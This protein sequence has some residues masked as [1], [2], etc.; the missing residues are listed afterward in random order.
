MLPP[1]VI[2]L[3]LHGYRSFNP[4]THLST[5][6]YSSALKHYL[7]ISE[8]HKVGDSLNLEPASQIGVAIG[9]YFQDNRLPCQIVG[10]AFH[11]GRRHPPGAAP[12]GAE[13]DEHGHTCGADNLIKRS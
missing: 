1:T 4:A 13:I 6:R 10:Q 5:R 9:I 2:G 11:L 12:C 8:N 7:T 3:S